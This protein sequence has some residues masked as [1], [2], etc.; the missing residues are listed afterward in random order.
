LEK[1]Q[2]LIRT[3]LEKADRLWARFL[4]F[5]FRRM[6][7]RTQYQLLEVSLEGSIPERAP[8]TGW[9]PFP[10]DLS[11]S[12]I[13]K[14]LLAA[15]LDPK[16]SHVLIQINQLRT[17]WARVQSFARAIDAI[18]E[19]GKKV[20]AIL[21]VAGTKEF[22]LAC[23]ADEVVAIPTGFIGF[24][25]ISVDLTFFREML[26]KV[27]IEPDLE[28]AGE[29]KSAS[30][31]FMRKAPSRSHKEQMKSLI[32]SLFDW[33]VSSVAERRGLDVKE[34]TK[35]VD[36]GPFVPSE[37]LEN[38]LVDRLAYRDEIIDEL[39]INGKKL[40]RINA[41]RYVR[42]I[43]RFNELVARSGNRRRIGIV[44]LRGSIVDH[45]DDSGGGSG[46]VADRVVP[47]LRALRRDINVKAVILRIS[48]PGGSAFASDRIWREVHTL[49]KKKP[50]IGSLGDVAAS[51]GYY[52][53]TACDHLLVEQSTITGSIGVVAGKF[54][55]KGLY[56]RL[57]IG[58]STIQRG[59]SA[60][61]FSLSA[62]FSDK[63]RD[64]LKKILAETHRQFKER[65]GKGRSLKQDKVEE[66]GQGQ[67]FTGDQAVKLG[68]A[69][70][71]GSLERALEV[72]RI[73]AKLPALEPL[74]VDM[75]PKPKIPW[76]KALA[77]MGATQS[78]P[79]SQI[80]E[81]MSLLKLFDGTPLL[82]MPF[83]LH[84]E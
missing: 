28:T 10:V 11:F 68:L 60:G 64:R 56:R 18:R 15:A 75:Y 26:D 36:A 7:A 63:E 23:R 21:G 58:K 37:A 1:N 62:P 42:I 69:D 77:M 76:T 35:L 12:E 25:G 48:S 44:N 6:V 65:V 84:I 72:A 45:R 16:I 9:I 79:L 51:G 67:V 3:L 8:F 14:V 38:K 66:V 22:T 2:S 53:A 27:T 34:V 33:S 52:I 70:E 32:D 47:L 59:E 43:T 46:I 30:E 54:S 29:N 41:R 71:F 55:L 4:F 61:I 83:D 73:K 80:L 19:K 24:S 20:I 74:L 81:D 50:V 13:E 82:L 78:W 57:G 40:K 5:I 49:A 17:G 31:V 39:K